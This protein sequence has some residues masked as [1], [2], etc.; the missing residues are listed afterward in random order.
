[1]CEEPNVFIQALSLDNCFGKF[2]WGS[3]LMKQALK[4]LQLNHWLWKYGGVFD[5]V[6]PFRK[7]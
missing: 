1:M 7:S 4:L 2:F 3:G 5:K 6:E